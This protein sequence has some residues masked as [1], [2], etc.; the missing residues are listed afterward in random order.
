[1][2]P[3]RPQSVIQEHAR[4]HRAR[5]T[6]P[7]RGTYGN[8]PDGF[9]GTY[10]T[11]PPDPVFMAFRRLLTTGPIGALMARLERW[12]EARDDRRDARSIAG[13]PAPAIPGASAAAIPDDDAAR[14]VAA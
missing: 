3:L 12:I 2:M 7:Q 5:E 9:L 6:I 1:M 11:L 8:D 13:S 4:E 10:D 14:P